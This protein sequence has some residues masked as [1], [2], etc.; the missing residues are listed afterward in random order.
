MSCLCALG[1]LQLQQVRQ[2]AGGGSLDPWTTP[3]DGMSIH[4]SDEQMQV[5]PTLPSSL[6]Q[7]LLISLQGMDPVLASGSPSNLIS[8]CPTRR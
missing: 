6:A 2:A 7:G 4:L 5:T 8:G 3:Q 1:L